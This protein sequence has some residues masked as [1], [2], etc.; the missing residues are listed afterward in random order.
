M[1]LFAAFAAEIVLFASGISWLLVV[2]RIPVA[3]AIG[4]GLYPFVF[5]EIAKMMGA[6][7]SGSKFSARLK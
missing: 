6:A 4:F 3:Q 2:L 7:G 5:G 1:K